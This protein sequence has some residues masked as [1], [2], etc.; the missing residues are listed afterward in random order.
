MGVG[1]LVGFGLRIGRK[2]K[3]RR[4]KLWLVLKILGLLISIVY[5]E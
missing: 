4:K 1:Q 3:K 5:R 2:L